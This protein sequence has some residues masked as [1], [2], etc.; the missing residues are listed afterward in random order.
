MKNVET[1]STLNMS[2]EDWLKSRKCGIGGSDA[3]A[4][5]GLNAWSSAYSVW[6]NKTGRSGPIPINEAMRQGTDL[7]EYVALRFM[8]ATGKKVRRCNKI[9]TNPAYPFALANIDRDVVGESA[10]LE[11]KTTSTLNLKKFKNG[12][13]P[14][15]YYV[16]CMHYMAVTGADMWYLA[17]LVLGRDFM[18]FEI[19][20]DED[21]IAALMA[22][23][24]DFW[25]YV[26]R[27]EA[28]PV[29][30]TEATEKAQNA[31]YRD[32]EDDMVD[33]F[34]FESKLLALAEFKNAKKSVEKNIRQIEQEVKECLGASQN[35]ACGQWK[36][37]WKPQTRST[38]QTK[39]FVKDH[40]DLQEEMDDYYK[41]TTFRKLDVKEVQSK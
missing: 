16:Q 14:D 40:P 15:N 1:T 35:G 3:A 34:G 38:F 2:H 6:M 32:S 25:D 9:I 18:I 33:L 4:I 22:S 28:P 41:L 7:E 12:E 20:R 31:R 8:E 19:P 39:D 30:G 21:E 5:V 37:S 24:K 11:C 36:V 10:G 29:D 17:V 23:E 26:E 13:Y 27:D